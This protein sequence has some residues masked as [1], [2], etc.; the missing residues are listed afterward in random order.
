MT[1]QVY[2]VLGDAKSTLIIPSAALGAKAPDGSYMVRVVG[3]DRRPVPRKVTIGINNNAT[4]QVLS[5][6][7]AGEVVVVGEGSA[8]PTPAGPGGPQFRARPL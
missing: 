8:T 1:A 4:A 7:Q 3:E 6:L 2:L 5:G